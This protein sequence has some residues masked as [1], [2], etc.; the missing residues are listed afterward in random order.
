MSF[1][2]K[3]TTKDNLR[4][5]RLSTS[6]TEDMIKLRWQMQTEVN[7]YKYPVSKQQHF[8]F[9]LS[10]YC[11]QC[12]AFGLDNVSH[13]FWECFLHLSFIFVSKTYIIHA[14]RSALRQIDQIDGNIHA[15]QMNPNKNIKKITGLFLKITK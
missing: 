12:Q 14:G 3:E 5:Y 1:E 10:E 4:Y 7:M 8:S 13:R 11:H 9:S 2:T 6:R 15:N